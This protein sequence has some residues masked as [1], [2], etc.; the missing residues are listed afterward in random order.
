MLD[1]THS[2]LRDQQRHR[3]FW[4]LFWVGFFVAS[5]FAAALGARA[6]GADY[7]DWKAPPPL[8]NATPVFILVDVGSSGLRTSLYAPVAKEFGLHNGDRVTAS[9]LF[10][11]KD[12]ERQILGDRMK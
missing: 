8:P 10:A 6:R 11:I 3:W 9:T 1:T 12:R 5:L 4:R 2:S 7:S